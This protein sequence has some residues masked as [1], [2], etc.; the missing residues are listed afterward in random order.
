MAAPKRWG[1][2]RDK[3]IGDEM[4]VSWS[5]GDLTEIVATELEE[6]LLIDA[7]ERRNVAAWARAAQDS[8]VT[9]GKDWILAPRGGLLDRCKLIEER[10]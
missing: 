7:T 10:N 4:L 6:R 5:D 2:T 1:Y 9:K 3:A 8:S